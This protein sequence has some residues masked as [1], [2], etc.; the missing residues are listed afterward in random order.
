MECELTEQKQPENGL[1][2]TFEL[3]CAAAIRYGP[4]QSNPSKVGGCVRSHTEE[5]GS[6]PVTLLAAGDVYVL[7]RV[8]NAP[9]RTQEALEK[10]DTEILRAGAEIQREDADSHHK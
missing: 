9:P 8:V 6:A 4:K 1:R 7:L 3:S 10:H 5:G 2:N